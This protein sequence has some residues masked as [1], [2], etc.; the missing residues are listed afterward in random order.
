MVSKWRTIYFKVRYRSSNLWEKI[1]FLIPIQVADLVDVFL[2]SLILPRQFLVGCRNFVQKK[3]SM[4]HQLFLND[5]LK[6]KSMFWV[7]FKT[8][9]SMS[10]W[11]ECNT[12]HICLSCSFF[13]SYFT[14]DILCDT[15]QKQT[16]KKLQRKS[17]SDVL[18][19]RSK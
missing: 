1:V 18:Q 7:A 19:K 10:L 4:A 11:K 2:L 8:K 9:V 5:F 17:Q 3:H 12:F 13:F 16:E 15:L 14:C 6:A